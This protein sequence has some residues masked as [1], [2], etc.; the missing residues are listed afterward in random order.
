MRSPRFARHRRIIAFSLLSILTLLMVFTC[1]KYVGEGCVDGDSSSDDGD[2]DSSGGDYPEG[3]YG[4]TYGDIMEDFTMKDCAGNTVRLSD[5]YG[6]AK[7]VMINHSAGWCSVC[8]RETATL[9]EWYEE[10]ADDGFVMIQPLFQ[11]NSGGEVTESFCSGWK[12]QYE[13]TFPVL[14]DTDN[15]LLDYHPAIQ[16]GGYEYATPLNMVLDREMKIRF[17]LEGDVP[18]SIRDN[19]T[20][21][22]N[23]E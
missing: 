5:F 13:V 16:Q 4:Y 18:H 10:L 7:A 17:L 12:E 8:R 2:V 23:E 15:Y 19:I 11:N 14:I 21:I 3:P 1:E 9:Q 6:S 22:M 20:A